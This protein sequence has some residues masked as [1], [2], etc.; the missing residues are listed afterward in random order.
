VIEKKKR[1]RF[2]HKG[3]N[4]IKFPDSYYKNGRNINLEIICG[5]LRRFTVKDFIMIFPLVFIGQ[6]MQEK[7]SVAPRALPEK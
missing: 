2:Y 7:S 5:N 1:Y 6:E 3:V 4:D